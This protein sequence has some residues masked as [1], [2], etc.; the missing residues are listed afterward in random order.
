MATLI[1]RKLNAYRNII[2]ITSCQ[3]M[4]TGS[5]PFQVLG[6]PLPPPNQRYS[7][8]VRG[9][10]SKGARFEFFL[11]RN[12]HS[13]FACFPLLL[14]VATDCRNFESDKFGSTVKYNIREKFFE[15]GDSAKC[16]NERHAGTQNRTVIL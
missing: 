15:F 11:E 10:L 14:Y 13:Y 7:K 5:T 16:L 1:C 4:W 2:F 9:F 8:Y 12:L 6:S 3:C